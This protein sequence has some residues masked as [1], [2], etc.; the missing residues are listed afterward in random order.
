M[1]NKDNIK[2]VCLKPIFSSKDIGNDLIFINC[3]LG[4]NGNI[5]LL[6][7]D[8]TYDYL[9]SR[10]RNISM[11]MDEEPVYKIVNSFKIVPETSQNYKLFILEENK[12]LEL[13]NKNINYTHGLQIDSDKYCLAC[14]SKTDAFKNS[15][16]KNCE[17]FDFNGK[18]LNEFAIGTGINDIQTNIKNELWISYSDNGIYWSDDNDGT[19]SHIERNGLNC[20]DINGNIIY[21]YDRSNLIIDSCDS[22]NVYSDSEILINIYSG[23]VESWFAFAKINN[24]KVE[25]ILGW[26]P[27]TK[28]MASLGNLLLIENKDGIGDDIKSKFSLVDIEKFKYEDINCEFFNENNER[29]H[30]VHAQKDNLYFW[31]NNA[32]YKFNMKQL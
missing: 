32:L 22:L 14:H 26:T 17:I 7:A 28:F 31:K 1:T 12:T 5:N 8:K 15:I 11:P 18:L 3:T 27:S 21:S 24:K 19:W 9:K 2:N 25:K 29:L 4:Y 6:F 23:S 20:F 10:K 16:A 30:C 13:N